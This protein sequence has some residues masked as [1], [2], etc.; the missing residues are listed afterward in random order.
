MI[1]I[2]FP[3][4]SW[5]AKPHSFITKTMKNEAHKFYQAKNNYNKISDKFVRQKLSKY[6][7]Q[8]HYIACKKDSP[9]ELFKMQMYLTVQLWWLWYSSTNIK[10]QTTILEAG[11]QSHKYIQWHFENAEL[12]CCMFLFNQKTSDICAWLQFIKRCIASKTEWTKSLVVWLQ[13][14]V[15]LI[16]PGSTTTVGAAAVN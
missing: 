8:R 16:G 12:S 3:K 9:K 15:N 4:G 14:T 2:L 6:Q 11:I 1:L 7:F 13:C 10:E 5:T